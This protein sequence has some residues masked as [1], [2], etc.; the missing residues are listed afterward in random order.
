MTNLEKLRT[1]NTHKMACFISSIHG[2]PDIHS[3][4]REALCNRKTCKWNDTGFCEEENCGIVCLGAV[5]GWLEREIDKPGFYGLAGACF[6]GRSHRKRWEKGKITR[7]IKRG[8]SRLGRDYAWGFQKPKVI[9]R[10]KKGEN[11]ETG[12]TAIE[13]TKAAELPF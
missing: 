13:H 10:L 6:G 4:F 3:E 11:K 5:W 9:G 2:D 7:Y 8:C 1:M 12:G